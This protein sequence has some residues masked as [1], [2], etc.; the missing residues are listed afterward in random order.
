[1]API[2][3]ELAKWQ[4]WAKRIKIDVESRLVHPRQVF[5]GFISTVKANSKHIGEHDGGVF[6]RFVQRCYVS[7]AAMA[8]R[9]HVKLG[10]KSISLMRLLAQIHESAPEFTFQFFLQQFPID[11]SYVDWQ[12]GAF[13]RFSHDGKTISQ[14][15]VLQDIDILKNL[16][17]R[18]EDLPDRSFAHLDKRGFDGVVTFGDLDACIDAL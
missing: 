8:I 1:M 4:D 15:I 3:S 13:S 11:P 6:V 16:S 7:H 2:A 18:I 14:V 5:R 10:D 9:S 17:A 12:S